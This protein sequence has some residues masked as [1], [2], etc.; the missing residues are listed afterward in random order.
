VAL[1]GRTPEPARVVA[2]KLGI[3]EV[4]FDWR[5]ALGE[6]RPDIVS[7]ATPAVAHAEIVARAAALGCHIACEKAIGAER[8]GGR[9]HVAR[10][11]ACRRQTRLRG[12]ESLCP[13]RRTRARAPGRRLIGQVQEIEC[14]HHFNTS[15]LLPYSWFHQ[16]G[17]GGGALYTDFTHFLDLVLSVSGGKVRAV[18]GA[19]RRLIEQAPV[20]A[21][22]HDLRSG[23]IPLDPVQA[24][25]AEWR[26]VDAD[27]GYTVMAQVQM[28][29]GHMASALFQASEMGKGA[30]PNALTFYGRQGSLH[31]PGFF[32]PETISHFDRARQNWE[33]VHLPEDITRVLA[34]TE[35]PVQSG[36]HQLFGA[37]VA[38]VRGEACAP[39]PT[40]YD[41]WM[42]NEIIDHVRSSRAWMPVL[43]RPGESG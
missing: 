12:D 21:P 17:Q 8:N 24:E 26:G 6:F 2:H 1:C 40:F 4:R 42:A 15:P 5:S 13:C 35:D 27:M 39:Y 34:Q 36:W 3:A 30:H 16:L 18:C 43:E 22:I 29:D 20:G 19:A 37:F 33:K 9:A 7:I 14:A 28:P 11:R 32:F 38:D 23:L 41:G 25:T 10:R 31:L